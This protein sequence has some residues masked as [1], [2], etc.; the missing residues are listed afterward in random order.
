MSVV[1]KNT[2]KLG[3]SSDAT[4]GPV[5]FSTVI[6][7]G[8]GQWMQKRHVA[9]MLY[10]CVFTIVA[11]I[12]SWLLYKYLKEIIPLFRDALVGNAMEGKSLPPLSNIV[13]PFILVLLVYFVNVIDVLYGMK[14]ARKQIESI[15]AF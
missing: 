5:F 1:H 4:W 9:G 3:E 14:K 15:K 7:P 10:F 6:Y 11:A 13:Q 2:A 8:T 12:F